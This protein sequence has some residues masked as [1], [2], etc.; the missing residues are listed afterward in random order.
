MTSDNVESTTLEEWRQTQRLT[1]R[2]LAEMLELP[3]PASARRYA[4]GVVQA[5][6][7]VVERARSISGGV[8]RPDGFHRARL[9]YLRASAA[10]PETKAG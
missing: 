7:D 5:P 1:Y 3:D 10:T 8:V 6:A 2:E 4:L 9:A